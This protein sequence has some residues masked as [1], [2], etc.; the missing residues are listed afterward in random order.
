MQ[1]AQIN[2]QRDQYVVIG[3][4]TQSATATISALAVKIKADVAAELPPEPVVETPAP[5]ESE[6]AVEESADAVDTASEAPASDAEV[7]Q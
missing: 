2:L 5:E 4:I 3:R 1:E 6:A 7:V